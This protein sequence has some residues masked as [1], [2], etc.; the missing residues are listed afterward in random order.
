MVRTGI[1]VLLGV[2]LL[3]AESLAVKGVAV[4]VAWRFSDLNWGAFNPACP[5]NN[6]YDWAERGSVVRFGINGPSVTCDTIHSRANGFA[7]YPAF[8]LDGKRVA[9]YRFGWRLGKSPTSGRDTLLDK[10][11]KPHIAV[12]NIDGTGLR[13]LC[14]I[15][16]EPYYENA[17]DWPASD[18]I[19][20]VRSRTNGART[21]DIWRVNV[22]SGVNESVCTMGDGWFRR[23]SLNL[24]ADRAA[25]QFVAVTNGALCFPPTNCNA[26]SCGLGYAGSCNASLTTSGGYIAGYSR[27]AHDC[28]ELTKLP[29]TVGPEQPY[30]AYTTCVTDLQA[31]TN[32]LK[33]PNLSGGSDLIAGDGEVIRWAVNS[34]KWVLQQYGWSGHADATRYGTNQ[35]L[36]NWVDKAG[37]VT[38]RN[39]KIPGD[40][41]GGGGGVVYY[42]NCPGDFWVDGGAANLGKYE[43]ANGAWISVP[44]YYPTQSAMSLEK[45]NC[46]LPLT[47]SVDAQGN[48]RIRTAPYGHAKI[49]LID[50]RGIT[51]FSFVAEN[52]VSIPAPRMQP[53]TYL[54]EVSSAATRNVSKVTISR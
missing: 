20:Y 24:K 1:K 28:I 36:I 22:S 47:S 44:G 18:W 14:E 39:P 12:I 25:M 32:Q 49:R 50:M 26:S 35:I 54:V 42:G 40:P 10:N 37:V 31:Y 41:V 27:S 13:N 2:A 33:I 19:Y 48:L 43:D 51:V 45:K 30:W 4:S 53:G 8:S 6:M 52:A 34:D 46:P 16:A 3:V 5:E 7:M 29:G 15:A 17:L 9:F 38:S 11:T 21:M 23:F